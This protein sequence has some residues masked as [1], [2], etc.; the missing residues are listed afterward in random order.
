[1][2]DKAIMVSG[3]DITTENKPKQTFMSNLIEKA[4]SLVR[5]EPE[6]SLIAKG[7]TNTDDSLTAQGTEL[8]LD[9]LYRSNK[10]AFVAD[11][12]VAAILAEKE[13]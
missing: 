1:M 5:S 8:F 7:I 2:S 3:E 12:A 11:Q 13:E 10:T 6:K 9:F 4:R